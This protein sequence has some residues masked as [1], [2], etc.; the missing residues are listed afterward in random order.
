MEHPRI[1][2][3]YIGRTGGGA[4]YSFEMAKGLIKNGALVTAVIPEGISNV[5]NW[6]ALD[7]EKLILIKTYSDKKDFVINS[8]KFALVDRWKL[9]K[10][11][12]EKAFDFCY[13]PMIQPWTFL[14]NRL[15]KGTRLIVTLHDPIPH[16]GSS[17]IIEYLT[18]NKW[19]AAK[20]D[21]LIILTEKFKQDVCRLY[22]K[23][24]TDVAVI[25]HGMFDYS[26]YDNGHRIKRASQYNF[27]F[28]GRIEKYKGIELLIR[29]YS[30]LE[31]ENEDVS[32]YI[33]GKGSIDQY[34]ND[35][36][37]CKS[38]TVVNRFVDD[39]EVLSFF[40]G[41]HIIT[42]L[43]YIDATQSGVAP[44]AMKEEALLIV[45]NTGG[46]SEQTRNGEF[47]LL[48]EPNE[49]SVYEAMKYA[50]TNYEECSKIISAAKEYADSL[51]WNYLAKK[52]IDLGSVEK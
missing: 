35:L 4:F 47:A 7:F 38:V 10:K 13:V 9:K 29:A 32:L 16:S 42:V 50:V 31:R 3:N 33:V 27:L 39:S 52:V 28:F 37:V 19:V 15:V 30:R 36:S 12:G 24:E 45:T 44:I 49:E 14:V 51:N 18:V 1:L 26:Q 46:L 34:S 2:F 11:L 8:I 17:K 40:K 41:Q 22:N 48:C 23:A 5:E 20:A 21:K 25:P 6:K 43:P